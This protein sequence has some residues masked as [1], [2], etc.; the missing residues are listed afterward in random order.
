M[1]W[2]NGTREIDRYRGRERENSTSIL[3]VAK[4]NRSTAGESYVSSEEIES[5]KC[6]EEE[7]G[8]LKGNIDVE[9]RIKN[10]CIFP[11]H[12]MKFDFFL[13]FEHFSSSRELNWIFG[14][15]TICIV[16]HSQVWRWQKISFGRKTANHQYWIKVIRNCLCSLHSA[17]NVND[18]K[19]LSRWI[20]QSVLSILAFRR[21]YTTFSCT[22][23]SRGTIVKC[24][25]ECQKLIVFILILTVTREKW[26]KCSFCI[27]YCKVWNTRSQC[28]NAHVPS[29]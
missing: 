27:I 12:A 29:E 4:A 7:N 2:R 25:N 23:D 19:W 26:M 14:I 16:S 9:N 10:L 28:S 6:G 24:Q 21:D 17:L 20:N 11:S 18:I 1:R 3:M 15:N 5:I 22:T 13:S 8:R